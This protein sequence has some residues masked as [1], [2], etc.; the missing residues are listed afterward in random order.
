MERNKLVA[1]QCVDIQQSASL[2]FDTLL[3]ATDIQYAF[4]EYVYFYFLA[5]FDVLFLDV[6]TSVIKFPNGFGTIRIAP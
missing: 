5:V 2:K 1:I 3:G 6:S 4:H